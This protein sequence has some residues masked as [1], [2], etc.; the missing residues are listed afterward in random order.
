MAVETGEARR[1]ERLIHRRPRLDPG[2]AARHPLCVMCEMIRELVVEQVR[3]ARSRPMVDES[4]N[5]LDAV[6]AETFQALVVPAEIHLTG[7]F[8]RHGFPQDRVADGL[9]AELRHRVD[10]LQTR[11]MASVD[12]LI[13]VIVADPHHAAFDTAPQLK[14]WGGPSVRT[15]GLNHL[16][17]RRPLSAAAAPLR[18]SRPSAGTWRAPG[19]RSGPCC[20][21]DRLPAARRKSRPPSRRRAPRTS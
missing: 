1:R 6:L 9:D 5:D 17:R 15:L 20:S 10:V 21:S 18:A 14:R 7:S 3:V 4:A 11:G 2:I 13:T 19:P 12:D 16:I 8:R